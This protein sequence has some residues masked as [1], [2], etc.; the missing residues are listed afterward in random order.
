M[1]KLSTHVLDTSL[2]KPG[3]GI[4]VTLFKVNE[5]SMTALTQRITNLDGRC[6]EPLLEGD[7]LKVGEYQLEFDIGDYFAKHRKDL[8]NPPFLNKV[9]IRFQV[10]SAQENYHVPLVVTPWSYSTYR[11]S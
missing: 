1:G 11:G 10:A 4:A 3:Q 2:G 8:P 6:D 9:I 5:T 7:A